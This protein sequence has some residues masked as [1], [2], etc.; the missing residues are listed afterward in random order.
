MREVSDRAIAERVSPIH[1]EQGRWV[2][3]FS[4]WFTLVRTLK[5]RGDRR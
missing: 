2:D 3:D 4:F 1:G 5:E